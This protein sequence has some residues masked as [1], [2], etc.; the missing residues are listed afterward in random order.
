M[1]FFMSKPMMPPE[2]VAAMGGTTAAAVGAGEY[3]SIKSAFTRLTM[4][5]ESVASVMILEVMV[6]MYQ[7]KMP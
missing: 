3:L 1:R 2:S 4:F 5:T 7:R 6:M